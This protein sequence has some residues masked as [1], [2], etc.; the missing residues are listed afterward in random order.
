MNA[1][2]IKSVSCRFRSFGGF[3]SAKKRDR[4][5]RRLIGV[6]SLECRQVLSTATGI[7][8]FAIVQG[9]GNASSGKFSAGEIQI[10]RLDFSIPNR[11]VVLRFDSVGAVGEKVAPLQGVKP[12][13]GAVNGPLVASQVSIGQSGARLAKLQPGVFTLNLNQSQ[14][15]QTAENYQVN[16][17]LAGDVDGSYSVTKGDLSQIRSLFG[18]KSSSANYVSVCDINANGMIN[19][20]D[21]NLA[22]SNYG[23][24]TSLRPVSLKLSQELVPQA[25][26]DNLYR[27]ISGQTNPNAGVIV[28]LKS[29]DT[30]GNTVTL[31][32]DALGVIHSLATALNAPNGPIMLQATAT[33]GFGQRV[34]ATQYTYDQ[35]LIPIAGSVQ[36]VVRGTGLLSSVTPGSVPQSQSNIAVMLETPVSV[37]IVTRYNPTS[38]GQTALEQLASAPIGQRTYLTQDQFA[39]QYGTSAQDLAALQSF[40]KDYGFTVTATSQAKRTFEFN[41]TVGQLRTAIGANIIYYNNLGVKSFQSYTG[42]LYVPQRISAIVDSLFGIKTQPAPPPTPLP[43]VVPSSPGYYSPQIATAYDFPTA[44]ASQLPGQGISIGILELGGSFGAADQATVEA[45][46]AAQGIS[47]RPKINVVGTSTYQGTTENDPQVEVMLDIEVLAS[48]LP[49]ANITMYFENNNNEN[50]LDLIKNACFDTVNQPTILSMSWGG[51]DIDLSEMYVRAQDQAILDGTAMGIT[52][53]ASSGDAGVD[54]YVGS[55]YAYVN[56]PSTSPYAMSVGGTTLQIENGAWAGEVTWNESAIVNGFYSSS[57]GVS[58]GVSGGGVSG[59]SP[60]PFYQ[61]QAGITPTSVNPPGVF[62]TYSGTG[63]ALPD[64]SGNS[65][66][67]TGYF[68]WMANTQ[69]GE[70]SK[71]TVGGTSAATPLW[72]ALT[73]LIQQNTGVKMGWFNPL[74][75]QIGSNPA[76]ANAFHDITQGNNINSNLYFP[77]YPGQTYGVY[78][79]TYLGYSATTGFDMTTGWGTPQGN[80]LLSAIRAIIN[81]KS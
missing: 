15:Q 74:I 28:T 32:P 57:N 2:I 53:F 23:A 70:F 59:L 27:M 62:N 61:I 63:R 80:N 22:Y 18:T 64:V 43:P 17:S 54:D 51:P 40:A 47:E 66:P 24:S 12:L 50:L 35:V 60:T 8:P 30:S 45:Y 19:Q 65:D 46:L 36:P 20:A 39:Q 77:Q 81:S 31:A 73:G 49:A 14:A 21:W 58:E 42:S 78:L 69:T 55:G 26:S 25:G 11:A 6:E 34:L 29:L 13:V 38:G 68:V 75:Y 37:E 16:I 10:N 4:Q 33:D 44:P 1:S 72:A 79:P 7:E 71:F 48:I 52:F 41:T 56:N 3:A 67:A 9:N 5:I 76:M